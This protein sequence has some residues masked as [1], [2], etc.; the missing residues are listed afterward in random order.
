MVDAV[1]FPYAGATTELDGETLVVDAASEVEDLNFELRHPGK[2]W[3][4]DQDNPIIVCGRGLLR[5]DKLIT[6]RGENYGFER[7]R[8]RL[9]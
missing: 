6:R 2:L 7:L 1:S 9:S 5:L 3:R 4:F 8:V